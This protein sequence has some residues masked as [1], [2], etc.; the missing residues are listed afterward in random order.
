[1]KRPKMNTKLLVGTHVGKRL[2]GKL[3]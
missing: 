1:M 3:E 2:L